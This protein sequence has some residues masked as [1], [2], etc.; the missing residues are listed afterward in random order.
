MHPRT[1]QGSLPLPPKVRLTKA[2]LPKVGMRM[3]VGAVNPVGV[4]N[5]EEWDCMLKALRG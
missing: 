1:G 2:W 3:R 5:A 4:M